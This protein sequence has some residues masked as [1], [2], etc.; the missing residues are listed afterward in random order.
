MSP[1]SLPFVNHL[2]GFQRCTPA[3]TLMS[4]VSS[5]VSDMPLPIPCPRQSGCCCFTTNCFRRQPAWPPVELAAGLVHTIR[6][7][8]CHAWASPSAW[9]LHPY[10]CCFQSL[11]LCVFFN[12]CLYNPWCCCIPY[13]GVDTGSSSGPLLGRPPPLNPTL[14]LHLITGHPLTLILGTVCPGPPSMAPL[15]ALHCQCHMPGGL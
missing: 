15:P 5:M 12:F 1:P 3:T 4:M 11:T 6:H 10:F 2:S 7:V 8:T 9:C 13:F 14:A